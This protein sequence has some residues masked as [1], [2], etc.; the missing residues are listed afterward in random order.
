MARFPFLLLA[1]LFVPMAASAEEAV[2]TVHVQH[3]SPKGGNLRLALYDR[4]RY[5]SDGE[6][7]VDAV[8]PA[9][10]NAAN[11]VTFPPVPPGAYAVKMFQ[12]ANRNEKFDQSWLGIPEERYGF[13]N[14]A[15]PD[16]LRLGPP[17]FEAAKIVLKPGANSITITLH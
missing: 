13:S 10:P 1:F 11:P 6:A 15:G 16:W 9:R 7:I 17:G 12:D 8:V 14:D 5:E 3:V 2:L 4:A